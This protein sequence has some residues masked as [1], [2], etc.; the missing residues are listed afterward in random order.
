MDPR[1]PHTPPPARSRAGARLVGYVLVL[2]FFGL[3]QSATGFDITLPREFTAASPGELMLWLASAILLFPAAC[4]LGYG[5]GSDLAPS[6]RRVASA[7]DRMS[8]RSVFG[9]AVAFLAVASGVYHLLNR[10]VLLGYP[11]TDDELGTD[12]G[13]QILASGRLF[14]PKFEPFDAFVKHYLYVRDGMMTSM[15]W[16]GVQVAWAIGYATG[17]GTY[18]F[19]LA[20]ALPAPF[21][22]VMV[23][24]RLGRMWGALAA[25]IFLLSPMAFALSITT[26]AHVL[27]RAFLAM[28]L[29]LYV[30]AR[31]REHLLVW[32]S[33][34]LAVAF[35]FV[36][37][38]FETSFMAL[39]FGCV[40]L[41]DAVRSGPIRRGIAAFVAG[42]APIVLLFALHNYLVT[43][44]PLFPARLSPDSNLDSA[45]ET[46]LW[47]RFAQ[48]SGFNLFLL[49]VWFLGPL[50]IVLTAF[51][52]G[53]DRFTKTLGASVVSVLGLGLL[54][55]VTGIHAVGPIHYSE[56][57]V[58]LSVIAA[59]GAFD[60][61]RRLAV[62][63]VDFGVA[64]CAIVAAL[65]VGLV[66][67]SA[68]HAIALNQ[69]ANIQGE[70]YGVIDKATEG[71][72]KAIVLAPTFSAVTDLLP[73][74]DGRG[75]Y[76]GS[77]R[78]PRLDY[79]DRVIV[80]HANVALEQQLREKFPDRA[81][82][83]LTVDPAIDGVR[84]DPLP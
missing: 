66:P 40:V 16:I 58:P 62:V 15:D 50:G 35:A 37:R 39:P 22:G 84:V 19:A 73:R 81:F 30:L 68:I 45:P 78:R 18:V 27:S 41:Y 32:A 12:Y 72:P 79:S 4:L 38:P 44:N 54:H 10:V 60:V 77:W 51:G 20:A 70:V 1:T 17:V 25:A 28:A 21:L 74:Y 49:A 82:F 57:A 13:G 64:A 59:Y 6:L 52:V 3:S 29:C 24:R 9:G 2:V 65:V 46:T 67:F 83:R 43:G 7:L 31:E 53:V 55:P 33:C 23:A 36:C 14:V 80:L 26:H 61:R 48:N 76:V 8:T 47:I 34:G 5:F 69:Q 42:A 11:I 71:V 75:T 63:G 56:C